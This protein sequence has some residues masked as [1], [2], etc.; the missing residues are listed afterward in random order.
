MIHFFYLYTTTGTFR[1][2]FFQTVLYLP[3]LSCLNTVQV[4]FVICFFFHSFHLGLSIALYAF[5]I[6]A[7]KWC[8][9][10]RSRIII[11][12]KFTKSHLCH[13]LWFW[14]VKIIIHY[15]LI[16]FLFLWSLFIISQHE[17]KAVNTF[18]V[19]CQRKPELRVL[20]NGIKRFQIM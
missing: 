15:F 20:Q 13:I 14:H 19:Q 16:W 5:L 17:M 6:V 8:W 9:T 18:K 12:P 4:T 1:L 11:C 2:L 3:F 10:F 7:F